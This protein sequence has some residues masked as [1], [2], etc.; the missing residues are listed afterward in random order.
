V[1]AQE[2][3]W[4]DLCLAHHFRVAR[5]PGSNP[6]RP[7]QILGGHHWDVVG[8]FSNTNQKRDA[9]VAA[10]AFQH[11][12]TSPTNVLAVTAWLDAQMKQQWGGQLGR[13]RC[14]AIIDLAAGLHTCPQCQV[15]LILGFQP[16]VGM[17]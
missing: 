6:N 17:S 12:P 13:C 11:I 7:I 10:M 2:L 3:I 5:A 1:Q 4:Q 16:G 9:V 14:G 15:E 8:E